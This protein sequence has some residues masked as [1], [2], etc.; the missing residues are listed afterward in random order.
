MD[1]SL[2]KTQMVKLFVAFYLLHKE[3]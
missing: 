3:A 2:T 1:F